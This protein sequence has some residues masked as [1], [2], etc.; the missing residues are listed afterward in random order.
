MFQ[1]LISLIFLAETN[2]TISIKNNISVNYSM[3]YFMKIRVMNSYTFHDAIY[4]NVIFVTV[5]YV[6]SLGAAIVVMYYVLN[7][8]TT[9]T[10][11]K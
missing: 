1:T 10:F 4:F 2:F 7:I 11:T 8:S 9:T 6:H 3:L 5:S